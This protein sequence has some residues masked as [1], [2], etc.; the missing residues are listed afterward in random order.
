[1][2]DGI[3]SKR[4]FRSP[5]EKVVIF[6]D[7]ISFAHV[8]LLWLVIIL[9]YAAIYYF[10]SI[11]PANALNY[12]GVGISRNLPGLFNSVYYSFITIT[13]TG[14]G[15]VSPN[16]LSKLFAI[17]EV[18]SGVILTGVLISK[19]I[20]VKQERILEEVYDISYEEII[21]R[22]RSGL[23]LFRSDVNRILEKVESESMKPREVKDIWMIFS[24]LDTT[25][26]N[27][28]NL[29]MPNKDER[30]YYKR[31]D[32]FRLELL[33]NSIQL[34]MNKMLDLVKG[35]NS[36]QL[37]WKNDLIITSIHS[38]ISAV[39]E[40]ID[41]E[42]KKSHDKKVMD[43][44]DSLRRST[45]EIESEEKGEEEKGKPKEEKK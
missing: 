18:V 39:R 29:I 8:F 19:L 27:I 26:T 9:V 13:T 20:G 6:L 16:G 12:R 10:L 45:W 43:K 7:R 5:V 2:A 25:L 38:D 4:K 17:L 21:D 33:L 40:I 44:L 34:S 1:M 36:H 23:Y 37:D 30:Y 28:K 11:S 24:G 22:L 35:L 15:D 14:Y 32:V 41:Y 42:A 31:L 3:K